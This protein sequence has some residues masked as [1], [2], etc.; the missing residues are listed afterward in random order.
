ML[1]QNSLKRQ[2]SLAWSDHEGGCGGVNR[3]VSRDGRA[4]FHHQ[5][6]EECYQ[7]LQNNNDCMEP[8]RVPSGGSAAHPMGSGFNNMTGVTSAAHHTHTN[9][10]TH[11]ARVPPSSRAQS[12]STHSNHRANSCPETGSVD[13]DS[14]PQTLQGSIVSEDA[15]NAAEMDV[16]SKTAVNTP[17]SKAESKQYNSGDIKE[18]MMMSVAKAN[19]SS[20]DSDPEFSKAG[21]GVLGQLV[22]TFFS[23]TGNPLLEVCPRCGC[24]RNPTDVTAR[25]SKLTSPYEDTMKKVTSQ[26]LHT[27]RDVSSLFSKDAILL[28]VSLLLHVYF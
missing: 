15:Q 2:T 13:D 22:H 23:D 1:W 16:C 20:I 17:S 4:V 14:I 27:P 21:S 12:L 18:K 26:Y 10:H 11:T 9:A 24:V 28:R 8:S 19:S 3:V 5:H 25:V 6:S 7:D